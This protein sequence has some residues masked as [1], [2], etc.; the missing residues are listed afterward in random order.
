MSPKTTR[1][2]ILDVD[3]LTGE[4]TERPMTDEEYAQYQA[5]N[6]VEVASA[7]A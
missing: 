4:K 1:P 7:D 2:I 3:C 6:P 5:D